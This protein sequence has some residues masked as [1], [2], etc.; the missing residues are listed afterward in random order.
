[1]VLGLQDLAARR[2]NDEKMRSTSR[3][4]LRR[5]LGAKVFA[6]LDAVVKRAMGEP[7]QKKK[8]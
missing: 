2:T 7:E 1:M 4:E 8:H 6:E 5:K 3:R